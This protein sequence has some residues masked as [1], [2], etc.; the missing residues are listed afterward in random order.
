MKAWKLILV[1]VLALIVL[2]LLAFGAGSFGPGSASSPLPQSPSPGE[3]SVWYLGHCGYAVRTADHL[4]IF[5]YQEQR[6]GQQLQD[7]T[8]PAVARRRLDRPGGDQGPQGPGVRLPLA[9]GPLR[10]GHLR[11][12]ADRS[13]HRLLLRLEGRGRSLVSPISPAP[14]PSTRSG[15]PGDRDDQFPPLGRSRSGLA[16]QGRRPRHLPQR[17]LP[18]R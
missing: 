16:G 13:G 10:S 8:R 9:R 2:V 18:A 5:D 12:E 11:L 17:R 15:R 1:V 14:G 3:A 7:E 4:L 6:D